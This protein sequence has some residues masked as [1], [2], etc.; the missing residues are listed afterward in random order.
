ML[1]IYAGNAGNRNTG[2]A[3]GSIKQGTDKAARFIAWVSIVEA[4]GCDA[5]LDGTF[6]FGKHCQ[7]LTCLPTT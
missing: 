6:N 1:T 3:T 4:A 7:N 5:C 2:G